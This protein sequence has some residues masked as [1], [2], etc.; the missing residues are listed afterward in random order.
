[1]KSTKYQ[2]SDLLALPVK[3]KY[4]LRAFR[5]QCIL[6]DESNGSVLSSPVR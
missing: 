1:L 4:W 2:Y 3:S 6:Q 5:Y